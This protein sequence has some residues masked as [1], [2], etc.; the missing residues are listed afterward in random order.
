MRECTR[1]GDPLLLAAGELR[2]EPLVH[3]FEGHQAEQFLSSLPPIAAF[4]RRTRS[5]NSMFSA[6]VMWRKSA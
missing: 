6:T 1:Y 3:A 2:W 5:A 4:T